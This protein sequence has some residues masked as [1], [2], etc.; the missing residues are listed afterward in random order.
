[1]LFGNSIDQNSDGPTI[2]KQG[3]WLYYYDYIDKSLDMIKYDGTGKKIIYKSPVKY[4][5]I[6][7]DWVYYVATVN[8][9]DIIKK[10]R[11]DGTENTEVFRS[12]FEGFYIIH[13]QIYGVRVYSI[14]AFGIEYTNIYGGIRELIHT[15]TIPTSISIYKDRLYFTLAGDHY[16]RTT[17]LNGN[18]RIR[19]TNVPAYRY[20]FQGDWVYFLNGNDGDKLYRT[21]LTGEK[22]LIPLYI[23]QFNGEQG[24]KDQVLEK[25]VDTPMRDFLIKDGWVY[26]SAFEDKTIHKVSIDGSGDV[27]LTQGPGDLDDVI[28]DWILFTYE[29]VRY[30]VKA[31]GTG[32]Q[33]LFN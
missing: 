7:G 17:D 13:P 22:Y 33:K 11:L 28:G 1:M 19:I 25:V 6:S 23:S 2:V 3:D 26:Y 18:D 15:G 12:T 8:N 31:D 10:V 9:K 20:V 24:I 30:R 21:N 4:I 14:Y 32:Q 16:I 29:N 27:K 5:T